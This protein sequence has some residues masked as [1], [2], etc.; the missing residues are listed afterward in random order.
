MLIITAFGVLLVVAVL[1][2]MFISSYIGRDDS[3]VLLPEPLIPPAEPDD[4]EFDSIDRIDVTPDSVQSVI[5]SLSRPEIYSRNMRI[6]SYWDGGEIEYNIQTAVSGRATSLRS[7]PSIGDE[8]RIIIT[9]DTIFIW[10]SGDTAP[11][12]ANIHST[13]EWYKIADE[14]LML[15]TYEDLLNLDSNDIIDAG[16]AVYGDEDCIY[17]VCLSPLLGYRRTFY[18]SIDLGLVIGAQDFD[19]DGELVYDMTALSTTVDEVDPVMFT[20]PDG[21]AVVSGEVTVQNPT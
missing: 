18:I 21:T 3:L 15:V 12:S 16:Y 10:N 2:V 13:D 17:A 4:S 19:R 8:K 1:G 9:Q 20:L 14:W 11:Y 6:S 5:S 7:L